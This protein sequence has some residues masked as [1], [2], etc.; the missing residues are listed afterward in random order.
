MILRRFM[1]HIKEQ[2]WFAVGLDLMVVV[3]GIFLGMQVTEWNEARKARDDE[4]ATLLR[5]HDELISIEKNRSGFRRTQS[6]NW[7]HLM[8]SLTVINDPDNKRDLTDEECLAIRNSNVYADVNMDVAVIEELYASGRISILENKAIQQ[9]ITNLKVD[10]N[11][12][13]NLIESVHTGSRVMSSLFPDALQ[14]KQFWDKDRE[15]LI[16]EVSCDVKAMQA[17]QHF[18]NE[19]NDNA[20]RFDVYMR[21]TIRPVEQQLK[22]LHDTLDR[23]LNL[24]HRGTS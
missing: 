5:M 12:S 20:T 10:M 6:K 9:E 3:V 21:V 24:S 17:N 13:R 8:S 18:I 22:V 19:L 16:I 14:V 2:N 7:A 11:A 1:Y 4:R 23:E 15:M